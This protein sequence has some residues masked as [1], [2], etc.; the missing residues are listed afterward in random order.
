MYI[1]GLKQN[2]LELVMHSEM[3]VTPLKL[4]GIKIH[5]PKQNRKKVFI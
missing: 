1:K 5:Q 2:I 3:A 4:Q